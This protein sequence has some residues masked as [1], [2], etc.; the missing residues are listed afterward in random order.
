MSAP[1]A[2]TPA[3]PADQKPEAAKPKKVSLP[4]VNDDIHQIV[5]KTSNAIVLLLNKE[6]PRFPEGF[7]LTNEEP[8][9]EV[10]KAKKPPVNGADRPTRM[11]LNALVPFFAESV[12][13]GTKF[14]ETVIANV[15]DARLFSLN[16]R[17]AVDASDAAKTAQD[18][19]MTLAMLNLPHEPLEILA[20]RITH[21]FR[22]HTTCPAAKR[23]DMSEVLT[24]FFVLLSQFAASIIYRGT[25]SFN[26]HAILSFMDSRGFTMAEID[27][28]SAKM[29][30]PLADPGL[31]PI[32]AAKP[33]KAKVTT[34][35]ASPDANPAEAQSAV[36]KVIG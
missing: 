8:K 30:E 17:K 21:A 10:E 33:K 20:D 24:L 23:N 35:P 13:K 14:H 18:H 29:Q 5:K 16:I 2:T 31:K 1:A 28:I 12:E 22:S 11:F 9:T 3:T 15:S 25:C 19:Q 26:I 6:K 7:R 4:K 34:P 32:P 36:D 27:A